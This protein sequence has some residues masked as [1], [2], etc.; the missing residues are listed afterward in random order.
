[1]DCNQAKEIGNI[2]QSCF[3][4]ILSDICKQ[5]YAYILTICILTDPIVS[6]P[7]SLEVFRSN[8]GY[9]SDNDAGGADAS[10][11]ERA[12]WRKSLLDDVAPAQQRWSTPCAGSSPARGVRVE[13]F[14]SVET[15]AVAPNEHFNIIA[16]KAMEQHG[17]VT[18]LMSKYV[19]HC[20]HC[21]P[22]SHSNGRNE[23]AFAENRLMVKII[24]V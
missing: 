22:F 9:S 16:L 4:F 13:I 11:D 14:E 24:N 12:L 21:F 6:A 20:T 17:K 19:S 3:V 23:T 1:M 8:L 10:N 5:I 2:Y 15:A 7:S 18:S